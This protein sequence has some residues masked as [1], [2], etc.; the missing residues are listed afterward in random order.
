MRSLFQPYESMSSSSHSNNF[1][2]GTST[3]WM[4]CWT[5]SRLPGL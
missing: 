2:S 3:S 1:K 4:M 5:G